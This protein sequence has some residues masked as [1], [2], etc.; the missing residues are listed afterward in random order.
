MSKPAFAG[1]RTTNLFSYDAALREHGSRLI[2][3]D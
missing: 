2:W 1:Y 3:L